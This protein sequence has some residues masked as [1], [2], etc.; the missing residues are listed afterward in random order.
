MCQGHSR[1]QSSAQ[2][3]YSI[4]ECQSHRTAQGGS[5]CLR[6]EEALLLP[7]SSLNEEEGMLMGEGQQPRA[8]IVGRR[9]QRHPSTEEAAWGQG[10]ELTY[11]GSKDIGALGQASA[12]GPDLLYLGGTGPP[13][14]WTLK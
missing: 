9:A 2:G 6:E 13:V 7:C 1:T 8:R 5:Q 14:P 10:T 4:P 12:W 11:C 3:A